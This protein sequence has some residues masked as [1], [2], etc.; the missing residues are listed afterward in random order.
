MGAKS[1]TFK[2]D[3]AANSAIFYLLSSPAHATCPTRLMEGN[4]PSPVALGSSAT[5]NERTIY[6]YIHL[7]GI[8][9]CQLVMGLLH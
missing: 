8:Q 3:D 9:S 4:E 7:E 2:S 1:V 5:S 6:K